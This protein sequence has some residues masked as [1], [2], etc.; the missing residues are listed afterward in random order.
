[1]CYKQIDN[2]ARKC[3]YCHHWQSKFSTVVFHPA[4]GVAMVLIPLLTVFILAGLMFQDMFD[5]GEEFSNYKDQITIADSQLKFGESEGGPTVVVMGNMM[6][7][8]NIPWEHIQ[9]EVRFYDGN[10]KLI[11]TDQKQKYF[12]VV[13]ANDVSTFKVSIPREFP[14]EEYTTFEVRVLSAKEAR[15]WW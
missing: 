7:S 4:F 1:M 5:R 11:D 2:R 12:F 10:K 9:L 8:S 13:P 6:N 3:P 14:E 15:T